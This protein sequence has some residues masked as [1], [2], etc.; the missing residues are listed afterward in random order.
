MNSSGN[1][2]SDGPH[3][4]LATLS[5]K[6]VAGASGLYDPTSARDTARYINLV[7]RNVLQIKIPALIL[8]TASLKASSRTAK[9]LQTIDLDCET[10]T[11]QKDI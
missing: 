2:E 1:T 9:V 6:V 5:A 7:R 10:G 4:W 8:L 3:G 11:E